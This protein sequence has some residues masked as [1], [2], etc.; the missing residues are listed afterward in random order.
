MD[1]VQTGKT[2]SDIKNEKRET[3]ISHL[4]TITWRKIRKI[5]GEKKI[6]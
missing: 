2:F 5:C 6:A 4:I 1:F 3:S